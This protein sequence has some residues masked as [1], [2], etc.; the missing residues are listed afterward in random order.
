VRSDPTYAPRVI[1]D[2]GWRTGLGVPLL[3][4]GAAIGLLGMWR[5]DVRRFSDRQIELL[6]TFADQAVIAIEN[7]RLFNETKEA[8]ERQTATAEI[9]EVI[10]RTT[11]DP[12]PVFKAVLENAVALT[13]ADGAGLSLR[14][15]ESFR[16][17]LTVGY[18][19][20][21]LAQR[22][23]Y[24]KHLEEGVAAGDRSTMIGRVAQARLTI[25]IPDAAADP[26]Y[27][28]QGWRTV[29]GVPLLREDEVIGVLVVR[30]REPRPFADRE[31][32]LVETFAHQA[33]IAIE[34]VRL[35]NE[36]KEALDHQTATAEVL[37]VISES[38]SD[39]GPVFDSIAEHARVLCNAERVHLWLR[40]GDRSELVDTG[41]DP[42]LEAG[43]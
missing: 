14:N 24:L 6:K 1:Q 4:E 26:E 15:G 2:A 8:L 11:E 42:G 41:R 3:R 10:S 40:N 5:R 28:F 12:R 19:D 32:R 34:N 20:A 30:R 17:R 13:G 27:D 16:T 37:K 18:T 22:A 7:A 33:A 36:T 9:L 25:Q 21:E 29:L 39:L 38:P 23:D 31:V 35:F 43:P